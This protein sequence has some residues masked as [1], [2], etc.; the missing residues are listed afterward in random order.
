MLWVNGSRVGSFFLPLLVYFAP[1]DKFWH[2]EFIREWFES[3]CPFFSSAITCTCLRFVSSFHLLKPET[4]SS[5]PLFFFLLVPM[6]RHLVRP[7]ASGI[8]DFI[9]RLWC[10]LDNGCC[11]HPES[12][13]TSYFTSHAPCWAVRFEVLNS[14]PSSNLKEMG[15]KNSYMF[16][17]NL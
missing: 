13:W 11:V 6:K 10:F 3:S 7:L 1:G 9:L 15:K 12:Y 5:L 2:W 17:V 4:L 8:T 16:I 14:Q